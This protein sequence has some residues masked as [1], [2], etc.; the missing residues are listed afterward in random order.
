M[1]TVT[2][3]LDAEIEARLADYAASIGK[4]ITATAR[5]LIEAGLGIDAPA[6]EFHPNADTIAA[7]EEL[8][9]GGGKSF[10]TIEELMADLDADD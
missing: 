9:R 5:R 2:L 7:I 1:M 3:D 6:R 4:D 8:E 10:K